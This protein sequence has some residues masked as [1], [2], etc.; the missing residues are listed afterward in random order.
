MVILGIWSILEYYIELGKKEFIIYK[1]LSFSVIFIGGLYVDGEEKL[2]NGGVAIYIQHAKDIMYY[3]YFN[4]HSVL[5]NNVTGLLMILFMGL[6]VRGRYEEGLYFMSLLPFFS[7]NIAA[8]IILFII[9]LSGY[10]LY[11]SL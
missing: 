2:L 11:R 3:N 9:M 5:R 6:Y 1:I 8:V 4:E 10:M 7:I